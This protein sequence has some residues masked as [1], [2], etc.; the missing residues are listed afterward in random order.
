MAEGSVE[1]VGVIGKLTAATTGGALWGIFATAF[2]LIPALFGSLVMPLLRKTKDT[3]DEK[4]NAVK[5]KPKAATGTVKVSKTARDY[6]TKKQRLEDDHRL[7]QLQEEIQRLNAK[8]TRSTSA[9]N[10]TGATTV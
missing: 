2:L 9:R 5:S 3:V 8:K 7:A 6:E 4:V 1:G 10:S